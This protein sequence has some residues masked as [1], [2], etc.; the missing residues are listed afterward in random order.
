M[1]DVS[2]SGVVCTTLGGVGVGVGLAL[3]KNHHGHSRTREN[4]ENQ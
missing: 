4:G 1:Y 2:L 3:P